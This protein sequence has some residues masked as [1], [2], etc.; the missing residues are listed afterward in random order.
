M[1]TAN[2]A[3]GS[4][5]PLVA[6]TYDIIHGDP[7]LQEICNRLQQQQSSSSFLST[8]LLDR[9]LLLSPR[10]W[11]GILQ[12]QD[13]NVLSKFVLS[14]L[15]ENIIGFL[16][17]LLIFGILNVFIKR[18]GFISGTKSNPTFHYKILVTTNSTSTIYDISLVFTSIV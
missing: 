12:V 17:P 15:S 13:K 4:S 10:T 7:I 5:I 3:F 16:M 8:I 6:T 18:F 14:K 2:V 1:V 9:I 11:L